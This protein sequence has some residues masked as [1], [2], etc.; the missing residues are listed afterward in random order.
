MLVCGDDYGHGCD[1]G[2]HFDCLRPPLTSLPPD[3]WLCIT[4]KHV[5][6]NGLSGT[7]GLERDPIADDTRPVDEAVRLGRTRS[8]TMLAKDDANTFLVE[9]I[10]KMRTDAADVSQYPR[11]YQL[12]CSRK[13]NIS[14]RGGVCTERGGVC[15]ERSGVYAERGGVYA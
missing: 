6:T 7:A 11:S 5:M 12:R 13:A 2:F 8:K 10:V 3:A 15:A 14:V 1:R 4:C 9:K